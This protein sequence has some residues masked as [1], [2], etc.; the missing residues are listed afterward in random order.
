MRKTLRSEPPAGSAMRFAIPFPQ[1]VASFSKS[2]FVS[3]S[4]RGLMV[5]VYLVI[6][7]VVKFAT[8]Q[9]QVCMSR[10]K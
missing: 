10:Q 8:A 4:V 6:E 3:G 9:S 2:V 7:G 1:Y 5:N